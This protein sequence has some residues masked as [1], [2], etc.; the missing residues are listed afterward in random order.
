MADRPA[1]SAEWGLISKVSHEIRTPLNG[2]VGLVELLLDTDLSAEQQRSVELIRVSAGSLLTLVNDILDFTKLERD[3]IELEDVAFDLGQLVDSAVQLLRV[4]AFERGIALSYEIAPEVPRAVRGDPSRLRQILTNLIGNAIKF[5]SEGGVFVLATTQLSRSARTAVRFAVR[6]TGIGIPPDKLEAIF[7]EFTQAQVSVS[8]KY[9]GTGLGL[10]IARKLAQLMGGDLKVT[11]EAGKGSEFA[12]TVSLKQIDERMLEVV[13]PATVPLDRLRVLVVDGNPSSREFI[14]QTL[15]EAGVTVRVAPSLEE[16]YT[17]L[18]R[19]RIAGEPMHF[20]ILDAWLDRQDGFEVTRRIRNDPDLSETRVMILAARGE[21]G[22]GQRCREVGAQAYFTKP[23]S[24]K[25]LFG[26]IRTVMA[27]SLEDLV[28][29]HSIAESRRR[30]RV[31]VADDNEVNRQLASIALTKRGHQV[32]LVEHGGRAVEAAGRNRYDAILMDVEMPEVDGITATAQLR[33]IE[34]TV[35]T[36]IIAMTAHTEFR[37][38]DAFYGSGFT[39]FLSK[40]FR[41]QDLV[42]VVEE[43]GTEREAVTTASADQTAP[44]ELHE[45]RRVM[46]EAGIEDTADSIL[47]VFL[48]DAPGRMRELEEAVGTGNAVAIRAAAHA[49]RSA[50]ATVRAES[51]AAL[52]SHVESA[53]TTAN[54]DHVNEVLPQLRGEHEAVIAYLRDVDTR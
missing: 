48:A 26:A 32:D 16:G 8:R 7:E 4:R 11:S 39:A 50:A 24:E 21:R 29:R 41:P 9:G 23:I 46:R 31:L 40:P 28:T 3:R 18:H 34:S 19:A 12:F 13:S 1:H 38:S 51:L 45:F 14:R 2:L 22:H 44:V 30:L 49:Y 43:L 37:G 5:T 17:E 33:K 27:A 36:P 10:P 15:G 52:L 42:R 6:D 53:A 35:D 54:L 25:E 47:G 20:A